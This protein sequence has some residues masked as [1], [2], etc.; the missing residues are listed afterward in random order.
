VTLET[1][2]DATTRTL[3]PHAYRLRFTVTMQAQPTFRL[4]VENTGSTPFRFEEALHT[5]FA[6]GD[7][8]AASVHG[9]EGVPCTETA[10]EPEGPWS[11]QAPLR[12][13][14]ETD[15]VFHGAP[16]RIELRAPALRRVVTLQSRNARSAIV[17]TPWPNKAARLSG[18]GP[19]DWSRF[20]CIETANC[21][22]QAI[23][24]A[25][26][27]RHVLELELRTAAG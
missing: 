14:A 21:K 22:Q 19:D 24:L 13:R 11:P 23:E 1:T 26:G 7:V 4:E 12:F 15:R 27:Q 5:Y 20:C 3:W 6:V 18:L 16:D 8:H 10:K 9:L 17:W 2:D 25:P